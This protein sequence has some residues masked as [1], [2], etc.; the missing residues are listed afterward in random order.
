MRRVDIGWGPGPCAAVAH[1]LIDPAD[2]AAIRI[3]RTGFR[4]PN[5]KP[6]KIRFCDGRGTV[7]NWAGEARIPYHFFLGFNQII[8]ACTSLFLT[9][10]FFIMVAYEIHQDAW[11]G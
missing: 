3:E 6:M 1:T 4:N 5:T 11:I 10:V 8:Q 9:A 2:R 7:R